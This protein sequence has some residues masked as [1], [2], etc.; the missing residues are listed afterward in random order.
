M[1]V[2]PAS[3]ENF[4]SEVLLAEKKVLIDFY[5]DWCGPCRAVGPIVEELSQEL[6]DI[7][8]FKVNID[9][10]PD[11]AAKYD[12]MSIPTLVVMQ[13]GQVRDSAVGARSKEGILSLLEDTQK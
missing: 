9:E 7:L 2:K 6:P 4:E 1:A 13:N 10:Q 11:L 5:A 3:K 8:F 12:V